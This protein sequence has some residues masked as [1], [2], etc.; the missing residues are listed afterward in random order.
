MD[1]KL[2]E[3]ISPISD[4][5]VQ[6]TIKEL[7][8][9]PGFKHAVYYAIPNL[10][11][12]EFVMQ[13]SSF[14]TKKDFQQKMVYP[15]VIMLAK[16]CSTNIRT[17]NWENL[18]K[19]HEHAILSNHRDIILDA[20]LMNIYRHEFGFDTTEIAIGD[21]L[22]IHPWIEKLVKLNKSFIVKRGLS[23][24][25][26]LTE[27]KHLAEYIYYVLTKKGQS[28]WIAQR[29]G[30]AKDADDRTQPSL[31][32]MLTLHS[33]KNNFLED[34]MA[35][36]IVPLSI[37]YEY[38]PCDYLKAQEFQLKRDNPEYKKTQRDDLLNMEIGLLGQKGEIV[39]RYGKCINDELKKLEGIDKREQVEL[40]AKIIDK[41]IH[42]N[43]EIFK[44][45]YIA[46]DL[47]TE[48]NRFQNEGKYTEENKEEFLLYLNK[49]IDK[50]ELE[51]EKRD[52]PFLKE[53]M[54]TM[55]SNA[56]KNHLKARNIPL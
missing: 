44:C 26:Q 17:E 35:L 25:Q 15:V 9:D 23:V 16:R 4:D 30:R 14:K 43:Y 36:N 5:K 1:S 24:R 2:F 38:D 18:S 7:L 6:E 48:K 45:N 11:W 47:L 46:Y 13:M 27:S 37:S 56:L 31:L 42:S 12:D 28:V 32:K 34:L 21:N 8:A 41:E 20:G 29:E 49:Q 55:Y 54:L 40:A 10:D 33:T 51:K 53:T 22:L 19:T 50:M 39:F 52:I 3:D